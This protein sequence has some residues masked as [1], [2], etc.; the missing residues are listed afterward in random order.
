MGGMC[1]L[2]FW[3]IS[4]CD[5][6]W[7]SWGYCEQHMQHTLDIFTVVGRDLCLHSLCGDGGGEQML[8]DNVI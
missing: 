8:K 2:H 6:K 4:S 1:D 3:E 7:L 5:P